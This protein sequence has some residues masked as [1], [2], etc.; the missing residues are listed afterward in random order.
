MPE[1]LNILVKTSPSTDGSIAKAL[2]DDGHNVFVANRFFQASACCARNKIDLYIVDLYDKDSYLTDFDESSV[3]EATVTSFGN[4]AGY[5]WL[6]RY[7]YPNSKD[8][9]EEK[10]RTMIFCYG[11]YFLEAFTQLIGEDDLKGITVLNYLKCADKEG[12]FIGEIKKKISEL[13][14][15]N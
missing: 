15:T 3:K 2:E 11:H 8:Q 1:V 6:K 12:G 5:I 9:E 4:L 14:K 13:Q 7:I 10:R